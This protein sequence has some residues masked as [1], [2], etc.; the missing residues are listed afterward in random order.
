M[1]TNRNSKKWKTRV[2]ISVR[3]N[4]DWTKKPKN[5][6]SHFYILMYT[7]TIPVLADVDLIWYFVMWTFPI[8]RRR[9]HERTIIPTVPVWYLTRIVIMVYRCVYGACIRNSSLGE[10]RGC[11]FRLVYIYDH[12]AFVSMIHFNLSK[13][14]IFIN[15]KNKSKIENIIISTRKLCGKFN[16]SN[17]ILLKIHKKITQTQRIFKSSRH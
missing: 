11:L 4:P 15:I 13:L 12:G 1:S 5:Y 9:C 10:A 2:G 3:R 7:R 17:K 8:V 6:L 14:P 16:G